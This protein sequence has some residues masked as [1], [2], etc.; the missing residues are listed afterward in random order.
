M[1]Q[2]VSENWALGEGLSSW[3]GSHC[4]LLSPELPAR[5]EEEEEEVVEATSRKTIGC[6]RTSAL[7]HFLW[8]VGAGRRPLEV[9]VQRSRAP[10]KTVSCTS[11]PC[12][13]FLLP[14]LLAT[15]LCK[16]EQAAC[17]FLR[18]LF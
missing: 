9:L 17:F 2:D 5:P 14:L 15:Q 7:L 8:R 11:P 1:P 6:R 3:E 18:A 13:P 4:T 10:R 12:K 16:T